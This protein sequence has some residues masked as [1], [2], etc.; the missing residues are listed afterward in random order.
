MKKTTKNQEIIREE[1]SIRS[2]QNKIE[3]PAV[4]AIEIVDD[5]TDDDTAITKNTKR[6]IESSLG[7]GYQN[8]LGTSSKPKFE[9]YKYSQ[10]DI[11]AYRGPAKN[12]FSA[13]NNHRQHHNDNQ[14]QIQKSITYELGTRVHHLPA[15]ENDAKNYQDTKSHHE[16][17][18]TLFT[19]LDQQGH[20]GQ[21]SEQFPPQVY[22][23]MSSHV[24]I[25]VL[26]VYTNQLGNAENLYPNLPQSHPYSGINSINL[27]SLLSNYMSTMIH[28]APQVYLDPQKNYHQHYDVDDEEVPSGLQT[29]ENYPD[30]AHTRVI[31]HKEPKQTKTTESYYQVPTHYNYETQ[32]SAPSYMYITPEVNPSNYYYIETNQPQ[33]QQQQQ[34]QEHHQNYY[35]QYVYQEPIHN[36][37]IAAE[38]LYNHHAQSIPQTNVEVL[39]N[40]GKGPTYLP[41]P[42]TPRKVRDNKRNK[43]GLR[44][45]SSS[46]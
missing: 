25:I 36:Q 23:S 42:A 12:Y 41:I 45:K 33:H 34:Q 31:F 19:T 27:Q 1:K 18:I 26:R 14:F 10:H 4:V 44:K 13:K 8:S 24:P 5:D 40:E 9:I 2:R 43:D 7:Y 6:T 46:V 38:Q 37:N 28:N 22:Q 35:Q 29:H 3:S 32:T 15:T 17:G 21:I 20:V 39:T 30:D 16:P 11:P